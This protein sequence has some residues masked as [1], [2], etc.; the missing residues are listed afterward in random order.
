M[1]ESLF[2]TRT[3]LIVPQ[4][5]KELLTRN[6]LMDLLSNLLDYR[7]IIIAA[8]AGY[9]KTSLMIDF[10]SRFEWPVCWYAL[11]PLDS[12]V[13]RFLTHFIHAI[14]VQFPDFGNEALTML[15]STSAEEN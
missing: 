5:R 9:G 6:R 1:A 4:R 15:R 2:V 11:E 10:A 14:R 8:P 3:K 7:L 13:Q 12:D